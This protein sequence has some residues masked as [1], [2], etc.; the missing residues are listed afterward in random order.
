[1]YELPD[2]KKKNKKPHVYIDILLSVFFYCCVLVKN[3]CEFLKFV[4]IEC[5]RN[6]K[7]PHLLMYGNKKK[8]IRAILLHTLCSTKNK[9]TNAIIILFFSCN[10]MWG[11]NYYRTKIGNMN[12]YLILNCCAFD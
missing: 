9:F 4:Q 8:K 10:I 3:Y 11:P 5:H 1:M 6:G 12:N 2:K 7:S